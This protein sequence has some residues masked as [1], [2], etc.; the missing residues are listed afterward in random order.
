[1]WYP[2]ES[3]IKEED[4]FSFAFKFHALGT[5]YLSIRPQQM[6]STMRTT[7]AVTST[8]DNSPATIKP[9]VE[10]IYLLINAKVKSLMWQRIMCLLECLQN[11]LP[12]VHRV[13]LFPSPEG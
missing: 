11:F 9:S 6:I 12:C 7:A 1:M 5:I 4:A 2:T 10:K 3:A 13:L 8:K